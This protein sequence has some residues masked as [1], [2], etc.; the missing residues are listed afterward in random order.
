MPFQ[1]LSLDGYENHGKSL[2]KAM[3]MSSLWKFVR[4]YIRGYSKGCNL[5]AYC[6]YVMFTNCISNCKR[7]NDIKI[8]CSQ[9]WNIYSKTHQGFVT[10]KTQ[11]CNNPNVN[12]KKLKIK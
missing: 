11:T 8:T 7:T 1:P 3:S 5:W 4:G 9:I 12:I 6:F 2:M 10:P